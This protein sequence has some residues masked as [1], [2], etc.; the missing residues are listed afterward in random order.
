MR[1]PLAAVSQPLYLEL[2]RL[3]PFGMGNPEPTFLSER[4]ELKDIRQLGAEGKHLK[5]LLQEDYGPILEAVAFG[6]GDLY[7]SLHTG[8]LVD[9]VYTIDENTWKGNTKLQLKIKDVKSST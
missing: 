3:S 1:L 8:D 9:V 7:S 2:Q 4:V 6:M 5:L